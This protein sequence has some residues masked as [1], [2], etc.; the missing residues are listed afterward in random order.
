MKPTTLVNNLQNCL[1]SASK[2]NLPVTLINCI[3]FGSLFYGKPNPSDLDCLVFY[4]K[5]TEQQ[6]TWELFH[7]LV[8]QDSPTHRELS[9]LIW[10]HYEK[11]TS[12]QTILQMKDVSDYLGKVGINS[13]WLSYFSY[14]EIFNAP[15]G[16]FY[17]DIDTLITKMIKKGVSGLGCLIPHDINRE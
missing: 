14:S 3:G 8:K 9:K 5:S 16:M 2:K 4:H 1:D 13:E 12:F 17:P 11:N 10:K 15:Y 6:A 7:D